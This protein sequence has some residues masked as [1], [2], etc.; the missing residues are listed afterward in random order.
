[1]SHQLH[2]S[3]VRILTADG[4]PVGVGVLAADNLILTCAHVIAQASGLE[5]S[6]HFDLPLLAPGES[7]SGRIAF[8]DD[9]HDIA[10]IEAMED[11]SSD[12]VPSKMNCPRFG[13]ALKK[14]SG[15]RSI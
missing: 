4:Y 2:N 6:V 3:L 13:K 9:E 12:P 14:V 5:D 11:V 15:C 10:T 1:M 8:R 7:F